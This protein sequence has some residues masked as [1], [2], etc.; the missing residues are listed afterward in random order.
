MWPGM[1]APK[2]RSA[3]SG[4]DCARKI[5]CCFLSALIVLLFRAET[6]GAQSG[7]GLLHDVTAMPEPARVRLNDTVSLKVSFTVAAGE[8]EQVAVQE[9]RTLSF[10]DT[11]LPNYPVRS[12]KIRSSGRYTTGFSQRIPSVAGPGSYRYEAEICGAKIEGGRF[13]A[14]V[15]PVTPSM[16]AALGLAEP[17]GAL[18]SQLTPGAAER[19]GARVGDVIVEFDGQTVRNAPDMPAMVAQTPANKTVRVKI[20]RN[21]GPVDLYVTMVDGVEVSLA[22]DQSPARRIGLRG[23]DV[24]LEIDRKHIGSLADYRDAVAKIQNN[25]PTL[26]LVRRGEITFFLAEAIRTEGNPRPFGVLDCR[27]ASATFEVSR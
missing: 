17:A 26:L 15:Q 4:S 3:L 1:N 22:E 25:K 24:I 10:A 6:V 8:K 18:V 13:S 20:L 23:G 7:K 5:A 19:A 21:G 9:I 11:T 2:S 14:R 27:T 16:A 12:E